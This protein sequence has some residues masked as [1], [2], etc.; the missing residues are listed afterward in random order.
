VHPFPWVSHGRS[1]GRSASPN[2]KS[3]VERDKYPGARVE[4]WGI[5]ITKV[6]AVGNAATTCKCACVHI[7]VRTVGN[8]E[9]IFLPFIERLAIFDAVL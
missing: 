7:W 6:I 1:Y 2:R 9:P 3:Q 8:E 5:S 4:V